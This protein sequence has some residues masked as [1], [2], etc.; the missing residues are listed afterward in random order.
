MLKRSTILL[1]DNVDTLAIGS[2]DGIHLGHRQLIK[3]LGENGALF[4]VD[5]DQANLTPGIKRSEYTGYPCMFCHFLKVKNLSGVE[6]IALLK[7][8]FPNLKKI[9][10][11]YDFRFGQN[12]SFHAED[13]KN[14]FEGEVE[15]VPAFTYKGTA[16]HS[17]TIRSFLVEGNIEEANRFLGREY[18][19]VGD[20]VAGQGIGE[21]ELVPTINLKVMYYLIP[22]E[23]VY[24]TRTRIGATVYDS[25]S[26]I[27]KRLSTDSSFAIETHIIDETI[28][29]K[30]QNVGVIFV[31][32]LRD[33]QKFE[34]LDAL[35]EQIKEDIAEAKKALR[36]CTL[37][38]SDFLT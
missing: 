32:H 28:E 23:G 5:K 25:V 38:L 15:I 21:K 36:S 9:V 14:F 1:K 18:A 2:F 17:S 12:R 35:K 20:S 4:V 16:I 29:G 31:K 34:H 11:G 10:V 24:A 19:I 27:G 33:N 6:F 13:L 22:K 26:F 8:E 7:K 37:Y 3:R 30:P